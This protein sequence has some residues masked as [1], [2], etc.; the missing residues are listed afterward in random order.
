MS[1]SEEN[2]N[3]PTFSIVR[4]LVCTIL[5]LSFAVGFPGN[6]FV[7]WTIC[8]RMKQR[9][10]S[11]MLIL[12]LAI[13]DILVLVTLP[14]WIYS[15]ANDWLFETATCKGLVFVVYCSMYASIFLITALGLERFMAVFHPF[16]VQRR[17]NKMSTHLVMFLIWLVSI[18][19]GA[20]I[21]PFQETVETDFGL[22][23]ASRSYNSNSQKVACLLLETLVGFLVPFAIISICYVCIAK[24][25][26]GM[27]GSSRQRS[28]R[29]V[30]SIVVSFALC[31]LPHH[32]VNL[33]TVASAVMEDSDMEA[34]EALEET[35]NQG[36]FIAGSIMFIN[37]CINP[38][39]YAFAA[40]NIQSS[41]RLTKLSKLFEQMSPETKQE[42]TKEHSAVN[43]KEETLTSTEMI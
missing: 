29:L 9:S 6:V 1:L 31:L 39:L 42:G 37:S 12:N 14:I 3:H 41:M 13:A 35:A 7:I 5:S 2:E 26:S 23:C 40:R 27:R 28:N 34:S 16:S 17:T 36:T 24:R 18:A 21:L 8:G 15:F 32:V 30:A 4:F 38:L 25:I 33:M 19:F 11:V 43:G 10:L 22:Q 20:V